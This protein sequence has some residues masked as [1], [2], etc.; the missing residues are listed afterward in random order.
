MRR[1]NCSSDLGPNIGRRTTWTPGAN[2]PKK[3]RR[4]KRPRVHLASI[5]CDAT[6][7][8]VETALE[9]LNGVN[10][11]RQVGTHLER[12]REAEYIVAYGRTGRGKLVEYERIHKTTKARKLPSN[13]ST[14]RNLNYFDTAVTDT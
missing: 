10:N 13:V 11:V 14:V 9:E 4:R 6:T 7:T 2:L 12:L 5:D 3:W 1:E 8:E